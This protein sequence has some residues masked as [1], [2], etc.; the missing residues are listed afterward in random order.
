MIVYLI[1]NLVN[2]K[3]CVG[4]TK[5]SLAK[6]WNEYR[7]HATGGHQNALTHKAIRKYGVENFTIEVVCEVDSQ[8]SLDLAEIAF[9]QNKESVTYDL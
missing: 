1:T 8:E 4:Q 6:R 2:G 5:R 9:I 7:N 3:Q